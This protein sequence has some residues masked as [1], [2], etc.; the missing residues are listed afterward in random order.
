MSSYPHWKQRPPGSNWGDFGP[1]DQWGRMNPLT[2][3]KVLQGMHE[4]HTGLTF[5]LSL[6]LDFPGG[7]V[8]NPRRQRRWRGRSGLLKRLSRG[9][10]RARSKQRRLRG[11][12]GLS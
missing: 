1:D 2:P 6:P 7:N 12:F 9:H 5:N 11:D 3:D 4:V 10:R 8:L